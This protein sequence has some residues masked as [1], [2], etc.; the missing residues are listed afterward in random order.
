MVQI[1][2][3]EQIAKMRAAAFIAAIRAATREA[4]VPGVTTK[5]LDEVARKVLAEHGAKSNFLGYGGFRDHLHLGQRGRRPRHP[6]RR[7]GPE[8]RRHHLDR[9]RRDRGRLARGRGVH[10][11]RQYGH[12]PGAARALPGDRGVDVGGHRGDE[13]GA[14]GSSTSRVRS[15]RTS[16]ASRSPAAATGI[17]EDYGGHGIGT[18]MHIN[19]TC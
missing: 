6:V 4:A 19:R 10:R 15:R 5:D 9:L 13:A 2:T 11:V 17:I 1:K 18:E 12:A 7:G 14:T 3:P 8:G 16:A